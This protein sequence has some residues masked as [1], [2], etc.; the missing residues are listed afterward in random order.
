MNVMN[1][2]WVLLKE[3]VATTHTEYGSHMPEIKPHPAAVSYA[4]R[5]GYQPDGKVYP[6]VPGA[7]PSTATTQ[8]PNARPKPPQERGAVNMQSLGLDPRAGDKDKRRGR[9]MMSIEEKLDGTDM[10]S[11]A[12]EIYDHNEDVQDMARNTLSHNFR[13]PHFKYRDT[14]EATLG[15]KETP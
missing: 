10:N 2:A 13:Q 5:A 8:V 6:N 3:N 7:K 12:R 15:G 4:Q 1:E 11:R 14:A 9:Q